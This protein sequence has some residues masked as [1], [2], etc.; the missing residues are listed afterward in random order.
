M[1]ALV[2]LLNAREML[3]SLQQQKYWPQSKIHMSNDNISESEEIAVKV[4]LTQLK[5]AWSIDEVNRRLA[6]Q[7]KQHRTKVETIKTRLVK[8]IEKGKPKIFAKDKKTRVV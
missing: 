3:R 4:A 7:Y 1:R 8:N 2:N 5:I 6:E